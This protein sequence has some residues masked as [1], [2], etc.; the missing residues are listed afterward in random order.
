MI[1]LLER[2]IYDLLGLCR[3]NIII[4][5][6]NNLIKYKTNF[7]SYLK[8]YHSEHEWYTGSCV[9]NNLWEFAIRFNDIA[10]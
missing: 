4:N 7:E 5:L 3:E 9:K 10:L 2:R 8:L 6:N 1:K